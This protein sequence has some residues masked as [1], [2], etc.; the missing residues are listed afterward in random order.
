MILA[1]FCRKCLADW[2]ADAAEM[3]D[4]QMD[5]DAAR[6]V[7]YG[8]PFVDWKARHQKPATDEQLAAFNALKDKH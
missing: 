6:H 8:E 1:G 5:R 7:I 2:L 4:H 3:H